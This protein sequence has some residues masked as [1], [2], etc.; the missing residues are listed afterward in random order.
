GPEKGALTVYLNGKVILQSQE[1]MPRPETAEPLAHPTYIGAS[2]NGGDR[3]AGRIAK[4]LL[5]D[6]FMLPQLDGYGLDDMQATI[7]PASTAAR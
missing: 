7:C 6:K 4:P 1:P 3:F 5:V 2:A